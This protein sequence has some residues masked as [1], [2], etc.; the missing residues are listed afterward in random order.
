MLKP[1]KFGVKIKEFIL[2]QYWRL[3][4][5]N[6]GMSMVTVPLSRKESFFASSHLLV[7]VSNPWHSLAYRR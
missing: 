1:T 7:V 4:V 2:S 3:E 5:Q 6:Q